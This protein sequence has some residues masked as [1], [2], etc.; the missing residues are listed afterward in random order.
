MKVTRLI[1]YTFEV[2]A[3]TAAAMRLQFGSE[4]Q[5][6]IA[7]LLIACEACQDG[8]EWRWSSH[9]RKVTVNGQIHEVPNEFSTRRAEP[10]ARNAE[11]AAA[12][13]F[14]RYISQGDKQ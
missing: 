14:F 9:L 7:N 2:T 6:W 11:E 12:N 1:E 3:D 8:H 10:T 4:A 13:L 5:P